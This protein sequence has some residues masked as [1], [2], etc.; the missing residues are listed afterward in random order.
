VSLNLVHQLRQPNTPPT[1]TVVMVHGWLGNEKVMWAFERAL[2]ESALVVSVR[3]PFEV[4]GG[5][6]W[7]LPDDSDSFERGLGELRE[8]VS[9][10]PVASNKTV[11]M[12]FSQGAAMCYALLLSNPE[13]LTGVAALAGFLP[14]QVSHLVTPHHLA[15]KRV[16]IA[17]GTQDATVPLVEA[18]RAREAM[19]KCGAEVTYCTDPTG[20][21]VG[22]SGMRGL[23]TWLGK[24]VV[25]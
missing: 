11:V 4:D 2:P 14:E 1:L 3:A 10:L 18:E 7:T 21:K 8:F 16:F 12:G 9:R 23:K 13:L 22:A 17:H 24:L 20:H 19:L 6:G 25:A 15:G 5:Y